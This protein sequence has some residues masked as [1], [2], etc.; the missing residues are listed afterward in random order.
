MDPWAGPPTTHQQTNLLG[1]ATHHVNYNSELFPG[2]WVLAPWPRPRAPIG[3][4]WKGRDPR[5]GGGTQ[6][7]S[8]GARGGDRV[9]LSGSSRVRT[10][11]SAWSAGPAAARLEGTAATGKLAN[12]PQPLE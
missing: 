5:A 3:Q 2:R 4:A 10:S 11:P 7:T 1:A 8:S 6:G 12:G 9:G